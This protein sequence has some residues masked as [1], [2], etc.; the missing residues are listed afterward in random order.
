[1][2]RRQYFLQI[3]HE[4]KEYTHTSYKASWNLKNK[5]YKGAKDIS[6]RL[7]YPNKY[8]I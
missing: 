5:K 3:K 6:E 4:Y 7:H 8:K 2:I 1:M